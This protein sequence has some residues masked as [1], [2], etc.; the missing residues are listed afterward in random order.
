[1]KAIKEF[2]EL[3]RNCKKAGNVVGWARK[4]IENEADGER[5]KFMRKK[6]A[7][8]PKFELIQHVLW[9]SYTRVVA[10]HADALKNYKGR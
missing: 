7:E 9:Q 4:R 10:S 8:T 6:C 5:K 1:M 3:Y 2:N